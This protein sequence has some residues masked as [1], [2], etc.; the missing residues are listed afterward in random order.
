MGGFRNLEQKLVEAD[1][2]IIVRCL[3]PPIET[4]KAIEA[5]ET[6]WRAIAELRQWGKYLSTQSL[7]LLPYIGITAA[8]R[9]SN[10][11]FIRSVGYIALKPSGST[12]FFTLADRTDSEAPLI[13]RLDAWMV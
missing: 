12:D 6:Y 8:G 4:R 11:L 5:L 10:L 2:Y 1:L 7:L 9:Q 13:D 3:H